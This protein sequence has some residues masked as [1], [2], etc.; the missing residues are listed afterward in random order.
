MAAS[1]A[2]SALLMGL[3]AAAAL[4]AVRG[5]GRAGRV[6]ALIEADGLRRSHSQFFKGLEAAGLEVDI[7]T[8]GEGGLALRSYD[9]AFYDHLVLFAPQATE[10]GGS[11]TKS[12]VLDFIDR[13]GNVLL[14]LARGASDLMRDLAAEVGVEVDAKGTAVFDHF[15]RQAAGGAEDATLVASAAWFDSDALFGGAARPE[16]PVLFR[17]VA[18]GV[19]AASELITVALSGEA[20]AYSHDP[21]KAM[22]EPPALPVGGAAALVSLVQARNNARVAVAGSLDMFANEA[23]D[24]AVKLADGSKSFTKSGNRA[25][26]LA[27]ALWTFQQRGVLEASAPRHRKVGGEAEPALYR[28]NDEVEFA[29]DIFEVNGGERKPYGG[30]DVQVSFV[31]LDPYLRQPLVPAGNGTFSLRF[32]VPDVYGVFKYAVD[33]RHAGYSYIALQKVV[34]VRPFR[35]DEYERFLVAAYPYYASAASTMAAFFVLGWAYLYSPATTK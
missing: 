10:L 16:G 20:T 4:P 19:P 24:A 11:I 13:G 12:E 15:S 30:D 27:V 25:F 17:G 31:M 35:H 9:D 14:A 21:K 3:L 2:L 26:A 1:R 5:G 32:T 34:P 28:I 6:L 29:I 7:K 33:Y 22:A 8:V 23:F 18:Q